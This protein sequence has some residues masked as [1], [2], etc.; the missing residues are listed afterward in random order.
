MQMKHIRIFQQSKANTFARIF[1]ID[2]R[3]SCQKMLAA[4]GGGGGG[5]GGTGVIDLA[6]G[7]QM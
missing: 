5:G 2:L 7:K 6:M 3:I 4:L 1:L